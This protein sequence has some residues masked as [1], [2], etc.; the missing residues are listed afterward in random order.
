MKSCPFC[1]EQIQ[2]AAVVCRYCNRD[3]PKNPGTADSSPNVGKGSVKVRR[4][5]VLLVYALMGLIGF[6]FLLVVIVAVG[7]AVSGR[8]SV[9]STSS[10]KLDPEYV[11]RR[12]IFNA[13]HLDPSRAS[14]A[15][16]YSKTTAE[17]DAIEAEGTKLGW[18]VENIRDPSGPAEPDVDDTVDAATLFQAFNR[19]EIAANQAHKGR[20]LRVYGAIDRIATDILDTPYITFDTGPIMSVQAFFAKADAAGLANLSPGQ[21]VTVVCRCAGKFGN[22]LLRNCA[23]Q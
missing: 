10:P 2:D 12:Q 5:A 8:S 15:K 9:S 16:R 1:A 20:L 14:V 4:G 13:L 7:A 21:H 11:R 23:L 6:V 22:V 18:K 17:L 3:Q 19:N